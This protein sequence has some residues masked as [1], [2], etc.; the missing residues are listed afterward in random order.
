M[1]LEKEL[2]FLSS[3]QLKPSKDMFVPSKAVC[4][5]NDPQQASE[6]APEPAPQSSPEPEPEPELEPTTRRCQSPC[7][8][9][10]PEPMPVRVLEL[11]PERERELELEQTPLTTA[12]MPLVPTGVSPN[13]MKVR[14]DTVLQMPTPC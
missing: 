12:M 6:P 4:T 11:E 9:Q 7:Q 14:Q 8:S 5:S 10:K 13:T 2:N 3:F 1:L